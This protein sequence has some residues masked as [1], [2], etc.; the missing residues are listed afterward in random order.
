[1]IQS[2]PWCSFPILLVFLSVVRYITNF[3][4]GIIICYII[5]YGVV[6][7]IELS[8]TYI[9]D[10]S[11]FILRRFL[12]S[13]LILGLIEFAWNTYPS[14]VISSLLL[15]ICHGYI[16]IK[17]IYSSEPLSIMRTK[18]K[19]KWDNSQLF[20]LMNYIDIKYENLMIFLWISASGFV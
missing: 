3:T 5:Y 14:T 20:F 11:L 19:N 7:L 4:S 18:K 8:S 1:M 13:L 17:L 12:F 6:D 2:W 10:A 9:W 15:H 16:L